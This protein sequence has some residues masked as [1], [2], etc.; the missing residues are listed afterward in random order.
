[1]S[2]SIRAQ[3]PTY[4]ISGQIVDATNGEDVPF[5]TI[6]LRDQPGVG[7]TSNVY[8]FYSLSLEAGEYVLLFQFLGYQTVAREIKLE[9]D[10]KLDIEMGEDA[11]TLQEVVV[12]SKK[13]DRNIS[14]VAGST[15]QLDIKEIKEIPVFGG[16]PD[17]IKVLQMNPGIK[18]AGEG[19]AGFSVRGGG[20]GQRLVL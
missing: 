18:S 11:Q 17:I 16:E 14:R 5:A 3:A 8:G 20:L 12:S 2:L 6:S 10:L 4:T 9:G 13:E 1:M 19:N 7:T 15:T